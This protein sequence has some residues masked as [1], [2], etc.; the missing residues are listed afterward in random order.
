MEAHRESQKM[1]INRTPKELI[2]LYW[3][4]V[5]NKRNTQMIR[6]LCADPI[7]RHDPGCV[8][9]LSVDDQIA[10]VNQQSEQAEPYFEH[11]VLHADDTTVTSVWNLHTRKGEPL[12]LCGIEVF[13][14]KDGK[15]TDCWNS[16]YMYGR[17]GRDGDKFDAVDLP[18]PGFINSAEEISSN[19]IQSVL[20]AAGI[21]A[22]RVAMVLVESIGHGNLSTTVRVTIG[23][24]ANAEN[25]L[26]SVVCK[27]TSPDPAAVAIAQQLDINRREVTVYKL[28]NKSKA[29]RSPHAF[30]S[31]V[32]EDGAGL[33]LV[34]EDLSTR[35][36]LGDQIGGCK[37]DDAKAVVS[38]FAKLHAH[39]WEHPDI[40]DADWLYD[41]RNAP[42]SSND[43][44]NAGAKIFRQRFE[45]RVDAH[46]LDQMDRF[47]NHSYQ[48][49]Q[50]HIIPRTLIH[51]EPR[52]D[53]ILFEKG[54]EGLKAWLIDWQFADHGSPMFD[55]AYFLAGS[56]SPADRESCE[57]GLIAMQQ[58]AIAQKAPD[59]SLET[60]RREYAYSIPFALIGTVSAAT[61]IPEGE[62]TD[63]LLMTLLERNI[64]ALDKWDIYPDKG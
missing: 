2:E 50:D 55:S 40:V 42:G 13:K 51:G 52:V 54:K 38:E 27:L 64:A 41:R 16:T 7:T 45:G 29:V 23:Y 14:A 24:N 22:P 9:E 3:E 43:I 11:E 6:E 53:N 21:E 19:W 49:A 59:Y 1:T 5:W 63:R 60:A 20:Y 44:F 31:E 57:E 10:R 58:Q 37:P 18:P 30:L 4:E 12:E 26:Q 62:H 8:T 34:M 47:V 17:W 48:W 32:S 25:A 61:V 15:F 35:T 36:K 28:L 39:F 33:N 56:L 46:C